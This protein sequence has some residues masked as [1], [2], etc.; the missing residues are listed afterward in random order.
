MAS[1]SP[2]P[3]KVVTTDTHKKISDIE[4]KEFLSKTHYQRQPTT[5]TITTTTKDTHD[6]DADSTDNN[7]PDD[8][9]NNNADG[10]DD[11][12]ADNAHN[13]NADDSN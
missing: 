6:N 1:H 13:D 5:M 7:Y 12:Y 3:F 8:A 9:H 11:N 4:T 10:A 2:L